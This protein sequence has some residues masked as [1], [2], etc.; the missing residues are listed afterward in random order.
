MPVNNIPVTD[1]TS[2]FDH[3]N[4]G[5]TETL[6][7]TAGDWQQ[8]TLNADCTVTVSGYTVDEGVVVLFKV[9]EDGTGGWGIT[10]DPDVIFVGGTDGQ[11]AQG[12]NAVTWFILWSDEG[13]ATIY[14]GLVGATETAAAIL[15]KLLT[16]D[17]SGSGLDADLLDGLSSA[18]FVQHSLATAANDFLVASGSGAFVK[19]TQA[20]TEAILSLTGDATGTL[21][22]VVNTQARGLRETAGPTTLAMGAVTDGE[23]LKRSG[24]TITSGT[25]P[26]TGSGVGQAIGVNRWAASS[27]QTAFDLPD[28]AEFIISASDN[29]SLVDP[30]TYSLSADATQLVFDSGITAGHVVLSEYVVAQI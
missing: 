7:V 16:V 3:G 4:M 12:A 25:P 9:I 18:A 20:Q 30:L 27:G 14:L 17:G 6:D 10:W 26:G 15:A 11:P 28:I 22:A 29:G 2:V 1:F 24:T 21:S 23:Y 19:K 13:D 5:S 8:G